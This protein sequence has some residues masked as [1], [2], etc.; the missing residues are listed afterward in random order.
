MAKILIIDDDTNTTWLL[1]NVFSKE[2][3]ETSAVNNS[4]NALSTA[5]SVKPDIVLL[6]LMMPDIDGL[7]VCAILHSHP[8]LVH[9]P[10]LVL[11]AVGDV[12][13]KVAAFDAGAKDF[14]SKPVHAD[15]LKSR[16]KMW[17]IHNGK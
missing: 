5:L 10:I 15:E 3:Y 13:S 2:G 9:V 17:V 8:N 7:E 11:S 1:E 14:I 12:K 6:D 4:I 16:I